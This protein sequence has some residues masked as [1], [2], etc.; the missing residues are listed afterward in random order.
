MSP[1][2]MPAL[3]AGPPGSTL[4]TSAPSAFGSPIESATSFVTSPIATAMRP[5]VTLPLALSW[6]ATRIASSIGIANE[7][8][9]KPPVRL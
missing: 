8:P 9:M 4:L 3:S 6:S 1:G 7:M 5:R 2:C